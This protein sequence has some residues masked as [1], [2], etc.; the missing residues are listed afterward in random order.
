M[1]DNMRKQ[2]NQRSLFL[3]V[4][5]LLLCIAMLISNTFA[6]FTAVVKTEKN[7]IVVG[8]LDVEMEYS[9]DF[10]DWKTVNATTKLFIEDALWQPGYSEVIYLKVKNAGDLSLKYQFSIKIN[11]EQVAINGNDQTF[12]LSDYIKVGVVKDITEKYLSNV[13]VISATENNAIPLKTFRQNG[14]IDA[15][16]EDQYFALVVYMPESVG[17]AINYR[18][19]APKIDFGI[20]LYATQIEG[21]LDASIQKENAW[22]SVIIN[23]NIANNVFKTTLSEQTGTDSL[24]S[25]LFSTYAN[26]MLWN[27]LYKVGGPNNDYAVCEQTDIS[28][29]LNLMKT[30]NTEVMNP[31]GLAV[32]E[33]FELYRL[34]TYGN[35]TYERFDSVEDLDAFCA[36]A[37]ALFNQMIETRKTMTNADGTPK[38]MVSAGEF[39]SLQNYINYRKTLRTCISDIENKLATSSVIYWKDIAST[40]DE[41]LGINFCQVNG[42][43]SDYWFF[44]WDKDN[45]GNNISII[46]DFQNM[47]NKPASNNNAVMNA[48]LIYNI[49]V[50]LNQ[51]SGMKI[52]KISIIIDPNAMKYRLGNLASSIV[53]NEEIIEIQA[54][55]TTSGVREDSPSMLEEDILVAI[56][57]LDF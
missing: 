33:L 22:E 10:E 48:G 21:V 15:G 12:R 3:S 50:L 32:M 37:P 35:S 9:L 36:Q 13:D 4:I 38:K 39:E 44:G 42:R 8:N 29:L 47:L 31:A 52:E 18:G 17:N 5:S 40:I 6:W 34:D 24:F 56:E 7:E 57:A 43:D 51:G 49:E 25:G 45:M 16:D 11:E 14:T 46:L 41:I 1:E 19:E 54:N 2:E 26:G 55:V 20:S 53:P 27:N 23:W 28:N 30:I